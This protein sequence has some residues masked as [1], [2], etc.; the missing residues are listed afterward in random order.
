MNFYRRLTAKPVFNKLPVEIW[1]G[2][3][4]VD[5]DRFNL[6]YDGPALA[7]NQ[8]E[9]RELGPALPPLARLGALLGLSS[10]S[11]VA[12]R[13]TSMAAPITSAGRFSPR[14]PLGIWS[15]VGEVAIRP[16]RLFFF[17]RNLVGIPKAAHD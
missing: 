13:P 14:G 12:M 5:G 11:P 6:I 3:T 17:G 15:T 8:M 9:A 2:M 4:L 10:A 1:R 16:A 7:R